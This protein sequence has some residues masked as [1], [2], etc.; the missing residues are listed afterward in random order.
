VNAQRRISVATLSTHRMTMTA[1]PPI[2]VI[3]AA[4]RKTTERLA[5]EAA[6]PTAHA[7]DWSDFEWRIAIAVSALQGMSVL[8]AN[9]LRWRGPAVW[10][11]FLSAQKLHGG[12]R[13]ERILALLARIDEAAQHAG[14]AVV[15]LKGSALYRLGVYGV[16]ERPMG[17][18]DLLVTEADFAAAGRLLKTLGYVAELSTPRH[19]AFVPESAPP[20]VGFGEHVDNAIKIELHSRIFEPLPILDTDITPLEFPRVPHPGLN[21]YPSNAA[22]MRHLLLHTAGNIRARASRFIQLRDIALLASLFNMGEW[23]EL[24][25]ESVGARG[26][27]WAHPPLVLTARYHPGAIPQSVIG[28]VAEGCPP[29]LRRAARRHRLADVSWSQ[30]RIQALPGVEWSTTLGEAWRF[31]QSRVFPDREALSELH[32][33]AANEPWASGTEWYGLAHFTRIR[34]WLFSQPPRVQTMHSVRLALEYQP[35]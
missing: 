21:A 22:L 33:V 4:L 28:R 34:R 13:Q 23:D 19:L 18:I 6:S 25:T 32:Y 31:A 9:L 14:L 35:P 7:P 29:L 3:E 30:I 26:L 5:S 8:L 24:L 20:S 16:G 11:A 12:L 2:A 17:D 1:L 27:W 15:A 10:E